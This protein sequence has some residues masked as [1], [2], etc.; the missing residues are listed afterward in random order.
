MKQ[1]LI[2]HGGDSFS[3]YEA[4]LSSLQS[5]EI[6]YDRLKPQQKW[7]TWLVE[8]LPDTD[9]LLPTFPNSFNAAYDEWVV[10]FEKLFPYF[11]NDVRLVGHSL[12]AMFLAKYLHTHVLPQ[13]I[14]QIVLVAGQYGTREND[15]LGSFVV[16]N[17]GGLER[18]ADEIHLFYST[19]DPVIDFASVHEFKKDIPTAISH[20]FTDRGH[21]LAPEFPELLEILKQK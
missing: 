17:A 4:Y 8:Q 12:G 18:S 2:I 1:V 16:D 15:D 19:D 6:N 13:K 9:V 10:Y 7:K 3:S 21:F 11:G 14:R 5:L 20:E